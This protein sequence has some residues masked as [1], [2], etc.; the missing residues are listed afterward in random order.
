MSESP[1]DWQ[2]QAL[3]GLRRLSVQNMP[4]MELVYLDALAAHLLGADAP[5]PPYT[6]EHGSRI[7]SLL[8]RALTDATAVDLDLE[9]DDSE[10]ALGDAREAVVD[11]AHRFAHRGGPGV[12][13]LVSR[14]LAAAVGELEQHKAEPEFQVRSLFYFGLLAIASG[15]EN[16]TNGETAE[17][18]LTA[19]E[20]WDE[21]IGSG[22]VPPWRIVG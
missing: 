22:F 12:H 16:Q 10:G 5:E 8:L 21:R 4:S 11:G 20:M 17:S 18:V 9:P 15:P 19:F 7:V 3:G 1:A 6:I 13:Q 14:F 2:G